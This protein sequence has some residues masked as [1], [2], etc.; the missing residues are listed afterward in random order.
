MKYLKRLRGL[1]IL[2]VVFL[3][4]FGTAVFYAGAYDSGI[5]NRNISAISE[6]VSALEAPMDSNSASDGTPDKSVA[7]KINS[8]IVE[9]VNAINALRA[10]ARVGAEDMHAEIERLYLHGR[11]S[12]GCASVYEKGRLLLDKGGEERLL[13]KY[14]EC[15]EKLDDISDVTA[16]YKA[17]RELLGEMNLCLYKERFSLLL[18]ENSL[19]EQ[20]AVVTEALERMKELSQGSSSYAGYEEIYLSAKKEIGV[21]RQRIWADGKLADFNDRAAGL[22][23]I[24]S[25]ERESLLREGKKLFEGYLSELKTSNE[26][27]WTEHGKSFEAKLEEVFDKGKLLELESGKIYYSNMARERYAE[28]EKAVLGFVYTDKESSEAFLSSL[29]AELSDTLE[30]INSSATVI[31]AQ[32]DCVDFIEICTAKISE[33]KAAELEAAKVYHIGRA[34]DEAE[35]A[36][37]AIEA[38]LYLE[39]AQKE[40]ISESISNELEVFKDKIIVSVSPEDMSSE[41]E[42]FVSLV[43]SKRERARDMSL[44]GAAKKALLELDEVYK[45][46]DSEEFSKESYAALNE[47]YERI[48]KDIAESGDTEAIEALI[49]RAKL[50]MTGIILGANKAPEPVVSEKKSDGYF[51]VIITVLFVLLI[52]EGLCALGIAMW[53]RRRASAPLLL[54]MIPIRVS[55]SLGE[56]VGKAAL[57]LTLAA[58]DVMLG[59]YIFFGIKEIICTLRRKEVFYSERVDIGA[60]DRL[61]EEAKESPCLCAVR[62]TR[63][64]G[65]RLESVSVEEADMMLDDEY[66]ESMIIRSQEEAPRRRGCKKCFINVDTISDNFEAGETVS[67]SELREKGLI[68]KSAAYVKVLARGRI[69]K[70]LCV[71]AQGF[72]ASAV[73]MIALTGGTAVLMER[74]DRG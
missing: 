52:I 48:K 18:D 33:R 8:V 37:S 51:G 16:L 3:L 36:D 67:L 61:L 54:S 73:K 2:S 10:D 17:E 49:D 58:A 22:L 40:S 7:I 35:S 25:S 38:L 34:E 63:Y 4:V 56:S 62:A 29:G 15:L 20:K 23:Y 39:A 47:I 31:N 74:V 19:S 26:D 45:R 21:I 46:F 28:L 72:S 6:R 41:L 69:N 65:E 13:S 66:A 42:S 70:P 57:L 68:P 1:I 30:K 64:L 11:I 12:G 60:E 5:Y 50:E 9:Y 59:V 24:S 14:K 55:L 27:N 44:D 32:D 71:K 53:R 43:Y